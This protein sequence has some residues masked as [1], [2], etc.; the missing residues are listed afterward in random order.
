MTEQTPC[1]G[2]V[3]LAGGRVPA[4]LAHL[5]RHRAL[6]HIH[7]RVMVDYVADALQRAPSIRG[8]VTV[9]PAEALS[10]LAHL[11]GQQLAA[12]DTLVTNMQLGARALDTIH[13]THLLFITGDLPLITV[14]GIEQYIAA[15]LASSAALTYP[16]IPRA[17]SET[18]FPGAKRT[19]VRIHEGT[20][21]GGNAICTDAHLLDDKHALIQSLY[22]ARKQPLRLANILGWGTVWRLLLGSL[23]LPYLEA[24]ATR[25]LDAPVRAIITPYAEMG[26]DVDKPEDLAA[27]EDA[28]NAG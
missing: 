20:F 19:Y 22:A 17:A 2:A 26:F 4:S 5:C 9:A 23:T 12:G 15:S 27:V 21:T 8:I 11:P 3:V 7:G 28:L 24:V 25:I 10:E 13:P 14:E 18:R 1:I 6:L 16:I